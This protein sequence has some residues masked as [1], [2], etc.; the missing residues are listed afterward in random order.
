MKHMQNAND[1]DKSTDHSVSITKYLTDHGVIPL[2]CNLLNCNTTKHCS[3]EMLFY[4]ML[5]L[6]HANEFILRVWF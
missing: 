4:S 2:L 1:G 5:G 6:L 3:E